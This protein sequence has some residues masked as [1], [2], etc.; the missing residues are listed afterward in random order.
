MKKFTGILL[1]ALLFL[2]ITGC[3]NETEIQNQISDTKNTSALNSEIS[4]NNEPSDEEADDNNFLNEIVDEQRHFLYDCKKCSTIRYR[5]CRG[6][7]E[8]RC[9][10]SS[11]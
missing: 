2:S 8:I 7:W 5:Y 11:L 10:L 3:Q 4:E 1:A 9:V 6:K